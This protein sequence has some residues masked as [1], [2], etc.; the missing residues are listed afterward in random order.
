M[1]KSNIKT[2]LDELSREDIYSMILF[3]L[4]AIRENPKYAL[5]SELSYIL[6]NDSLIK[7]LKYYAGK[8]ITIP[9]LDDFR[10]VIDALIIYEN[11]NL[12]GKD[13]KLCLKEFTD[14]D[15]KSTVRDTYMDIC[16]ILN[17]Y[18]FGRSKDV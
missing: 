9:S 1:P 12:E 15:N 16:S 5:L 2:A 10:N 7:F 14:K 11:V 18:D 8:T 4:W 13:L 3:S 6:D 17:K